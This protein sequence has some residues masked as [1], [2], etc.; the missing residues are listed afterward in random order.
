MHKI[1]FKPSIS[2]SKL[3]LDSIVCAINNCAKTTLENGES[4]TSELSSEII[5]RENILERRVEITIPDKITTE[6]IF[7]LGV[8]VGTIQCI[9][10]L[11]AI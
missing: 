4:Y 2:T 6:E 7:T 9:N 5:N 11:K 8:L 1:T 10:Q 3:R